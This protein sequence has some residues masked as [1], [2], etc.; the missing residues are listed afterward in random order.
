M[1]SVSEIEKN[2]QKID[3]VAS[4]KHSVSKS[5]LS[6]DLADIY[7][8]AQEII[9]LVESINSNL[10]AR[11]PEVAKNI[12]D[13][14]TQLDHIAWHYKESRKGRSLLKELSRRAKVGSETQG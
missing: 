11:L 1:P 10:V 2:I 5:G 12:I 9:K 4:G 7:E 13:L 14:E 6:V 8:S 3:R